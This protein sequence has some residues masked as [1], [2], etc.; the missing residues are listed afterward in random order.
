MDLSV[1]EVDENVGLGDD[2]YIF[3]DKN[4]C[5]NDANNLAKLSN[6]ISYE[7]TTALTDRITRIPIEK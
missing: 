2:V 1:I 5:I 4:N 6:T 3:G 7:M